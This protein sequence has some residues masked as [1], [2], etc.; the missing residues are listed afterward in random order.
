VNVTVGAS[1][2][3]PICP[4]PAVTTSDSLRS[5]RAPTSRYASGVP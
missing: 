5:A 1:A 4:D 3:R 2:G